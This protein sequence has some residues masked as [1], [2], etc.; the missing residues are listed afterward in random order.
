MSKTRLAALIATVTLVV[1]ISSGSYA[2]ATHWAGSVTGVLD[3]SY[4][5]TACHGGPW[6][7]KRDFGWERSCNGAHDIGN[8][9]LNS[10]VYIR[11]YNWNEA[12]IV[13]AQPRLLYRDYTCPAGQQSYTE[14]NNAWQ[15]SVP[16]SPWP[17]TIGIGFHHLGN[18]HY[19]PNNGA[20]S[21][22]PRGT[23]VADQANWVGLYPLY[24]C[25]NGGQLDIATNGPH[26]HTEAA[27][28]GNP[29]DNDLVDSWRFG[30]QDPNYPF[31]RYDTP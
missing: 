18:Y 22:V 13:N 19:A 16:A 12:T 25:P 14:Y 8:G 11:G 30:T 20:N 9:Y 3:S 7:F 2:R 28:D 24:Y 4:E 21:T 27:R 10:K 29:T 6:Y 31:I 23:Y 5:T 15:I 26:V 17:G 1:V